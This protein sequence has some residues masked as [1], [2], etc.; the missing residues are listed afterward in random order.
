MLAHAGV[1]DEDRGEAAG[2]GH[3]SITSATAQYILPAPHCA[4]FDPCI[5]RLKRG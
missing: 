3:S 2:G 4:Q 1:R 5:I